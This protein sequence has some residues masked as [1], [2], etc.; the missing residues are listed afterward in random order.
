MNA[1]PS[2]QVRT[3][4]KSS[5]P[6]AL[7]AGFVWF[8]CV[9][10]T[11][12]AGPQTTNTGEKQFRRNALAKVGRNWTP[13]RG[14][15]VIPIV[16]NWKIHRDGT[17]SDITVKN[18]GKTLTGEKRAIEAVTKSAPFEPLPEGSPDV[19]QLNAQ[20]E[21]TPA[22][23]LTV[24]QALKHYGPPARKILKEKCTAAGI[25]Y[26]PKYLT[27]VGLK[28]ERKLLLFAG[29]DRSN[30][31]RQAKL[32]CSYPL[33]S[34]SGVLGPKLKEGD[35]QIPEGSYRITGFQAYNMLALCVNYPNDLD[36]KNAASDHR[37]NLGSAILIHGGSQST[38]C[39]VVSDDDMEQ[40]FVA[41]HDVGSKN[42]ELIIAPCD[43]TKYKPPI[44][45]KKSPQWVP[46]LY[47]SIRNRMSPYLQ[48]R[49]K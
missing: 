27:L 17:V 35:L 40:L 44:D 33:V 48:S 10:V 11:S 30:Q 8:C 21:T 4:D 9:L 49:E 19:M 23:Q 26:P 25:S 41:T 28:K 1:T 24:P 15:K 16:V 42:T 39:L 2:R 22:L 36:Q 38:G 13:T 12:A 18:A 5:T 20:F 43:L 3:S 29:S 14:T 6:R 32:L 47:E 34:Y 37:T 45:L 31:P 7:I 46:A